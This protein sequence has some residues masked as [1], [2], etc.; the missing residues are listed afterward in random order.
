VVALQAQ[1]QTVLSSR[2]VAKRLLWGAAS[3]VA[4]AGL[5]P[6]AAD[7]PRSTV[8]QA[9]DAESTATQEEVSIEIDG[10]GGKKVEQHWQIVR[11]DRFHF[12][13]TIAGQ[14]QEFYVIG[15]TVY[16]K[17]PAG[18]KTLTAPSV[19]IPAQL[20]P[21]VKQAMQDGVSAVQLI[22]SE[23][24]NGQ[25]TDHYRARFRYDDSGLDVDGNS[26]FWIG[27]ANTLPAKVQF[28]GTYQGQS[29]TITGT[30]DYAPSIQVV[31][32]I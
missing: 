12:T 20:V 26:D 4:I 18:W 3:F 14:Q 2:P 11:P 1:D 32:P 31:P 29:C 16:L 5:Q 10:G 6:A 21:A 22:G 30:F 28:Q 19:P 17:G 15:S 13:Q 25:T 9:L 24:V 8:L 7:D 23:P 27:A